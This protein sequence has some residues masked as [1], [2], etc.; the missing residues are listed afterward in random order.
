MKNRLGMFAI[1][2][3]V[4]TVGIFGWFLIKGY[5]TTGS[6]QRRQIL[7]APAEKDM[8]LGEMRTMLAALNGILTSLA[9][10]DP[11]QAAQAARSAGMGMAVDVSPALMAKLPGDFKMLGMSTHKQFDEFAA[12]LEN[13]MPAKEAMQMM[14]NLTSKCVACHQGNRF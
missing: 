1:G 12:K 11:K 14:A 13:D 8:V 10:N 5:T 4:I 2:L 6:D 7:L 3:W 9:E